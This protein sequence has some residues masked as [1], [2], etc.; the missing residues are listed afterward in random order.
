[1]VI[2]KYANEMEFLTLLGQKKK[3][4]WSALY[5][6]GYLLNIQCENCLLFLESMS[7][8]INVVMGSRP[9]GWR[10]GPERS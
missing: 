8:L 10:H 1:M 2:K 3:Q 7:S 4:Y 5:Q 6:S 9:G